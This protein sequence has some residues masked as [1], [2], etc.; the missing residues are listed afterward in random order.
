MMNDIGDRLGIGTALMGLGIVD[1]Y[2][3]ETSEAER[4]IA[5]AQVL[6]R[7]GSN[8]PGLSW[9]LANSLIDTRNHDL[10]VET[11]DRY[12][13]SLELPADEWTRMVISDAEKWRERTLIVAD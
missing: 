11:T 5:E 6:L 4:Q 3:G 2:R 10:M 8:G 7:E 12:Q 9:A 1:H 13:A